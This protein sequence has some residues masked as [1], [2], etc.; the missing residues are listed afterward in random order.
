MYNET[1]DIINQKHTATAEVMH[2]LALYG[3]QHQINIGDDNRG[4]PDEDHLK[5]CVEQTFYDWAT[6]FTDTIFHDDLSDIL[7]SLVNTFHYKF[8]AIERQVGALAHE[9]N[10]LLETQDGSEIKTAELEENIEKY[11]FMQQKLDYFTIMRDHAMDY[12]QEITGKSFRPARG[13]IF[14]NEKTI[15]SAV[16]Q[17]REMMQ[18]IKENSEQRHIPKG[19]RIIIAGDQDYQDYKTIYHILNKVYRKFSNKD[20][21]IVIIHGGAKSGCDNIVASWARNHNVDQVVFEPNWK[22]DKK[23]AGFIRN[24]QMI[25]THPIGMVVFSAKSPTVANLVQKA[26]KAGI[27]IMKIPL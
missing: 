26:N 16:I 27:S 19:V 17:G 14:R 2:N 18:A 5:A 13:S 23:A 12:Y 22:K 8:T 1:H 7:Y 3:I 25:S 21:K 11:R 10:K 24:N 9:T 20:Q 15:T 6:L 4:M